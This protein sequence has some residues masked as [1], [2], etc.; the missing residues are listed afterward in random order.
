MRRAEVWWAELPAPS[1]RRPVV[2]L[3]RNEAYAVRG[4]VTVAPV[5]TRV[6]G[7]AVELPLGPEEGLP[8]SCVANLDTIQTIDKAWLRAR[9]TYLPEAKRLAL[10]DAIRVALGMDEEPRG[11]RKLEPG[12]PAA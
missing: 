12:Q 8:K 5:T 6:R 9:I 7:L 3:S 1:G 4:M 2:L 11:P 10:D